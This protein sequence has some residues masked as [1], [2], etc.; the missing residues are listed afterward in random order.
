M[1]ALSALAV[2][3]LAHAGFVTLGL[4]MD[5]HRRDML[6]HELPSRFTLPLRLAGSVPLAGAL[7]IACLRAGS[8]SVGI[9]WWLGLLGIAGL[10]LGVLLAYRPRWSRWL[11][12]AALA[13]ACAWIARAGS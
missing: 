3:A 4:A 9:L 7:C 6:G 8:I 5:R 1:T 10:V 2:L 12:V 11:G 13:F